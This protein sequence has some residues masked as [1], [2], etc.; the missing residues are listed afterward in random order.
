M[1]PGIE[2]AVVPLADEARAEAAGGEGVAEGDFVEGDAVEAAN[3][4]RGEGA[5]S[6]GIAAREERGPGGGADGRAGVV[7]REAGP[8]AHQPVDVGRSDGAVV[9]DTEVAVAHVVGDDE[10]E[11]GHGSEK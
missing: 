5:G 11:V 10:K 3:F 1:E 2:R 9:E 4:L 7:L 6:V 8:F